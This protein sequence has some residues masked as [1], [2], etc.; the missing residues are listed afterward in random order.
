MQHE[1]FAPFANATVLF[2]AHSCKLGRCSIRLFTWY[3]NGCIG[4]HRIHAIWAQIHLVLC[5]IADGTH[6]GIHKIIERAGKTMTKRESESEREM[7]INTSIY[8]FSFLSSLS[9]SLSLLKLTKE[10]DR[11]AV[12]AD[13]RYNETRTTISRHDDTC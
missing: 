4:L 10:N 3:F 9:F 12:Y 11:T 7:H 2:H 1:P 6:I 8:C 13:A 5:V